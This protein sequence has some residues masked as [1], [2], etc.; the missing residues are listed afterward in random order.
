MHSTTIMWDSPVSTGGDRITI[1]QYK[2]QIP[3]I[4]YTMEENGTT[5]SHTITAD[6]TNVMLDTPYEI[7]VTA[8][9]T[10]EDESVPAHIAIN[11]EA[12]G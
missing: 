8:I 2:I 6:S 10:C 1:L 12:S 7:E 4:N 3:S 11:I 9:N 5:R